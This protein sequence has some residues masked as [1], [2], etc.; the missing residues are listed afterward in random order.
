MTDQELLR[1]LDQIADKALDYGFPQSDLTPGWALEQLGPECSSGQEPL[2]RRRAVQWN[3]VI[4]HLLDTDGSPIALC[5]HERV[6]WRQPRLAG[7]HIFW[8]PPII[9]NNPSAPGIGEICPRCREVYNGARLES[10]Q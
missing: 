9:E 10:G 3:R 6:A 7:K 2:V 4:I 8:S 1:R 5:G